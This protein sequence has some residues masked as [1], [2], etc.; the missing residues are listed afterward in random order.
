M[1]KMMKATIRN[2]RATASGKVY[3]AN[4]NTRAETRAQ[5]RHIDHERTEQNIN[6][7]FTNDGRVVRCG[8][9]DA[10]AFELQRYE[11]LYGEGQ[12]AKN[13][14]YIQDGH[15]ER[16]K[17]VTEVYSSRRTAPLETILQ[18]GSRD[19]DIDPQERREKLMKAAAKLITNMQQRWG[20]NIHLL[21]F[22][23]HMD[24]SGAD[25]I[26][27]R[28]TFSSL[29]RFGFRVPNQAQAF[30]A[31]GIQRPD[32]T[33]KEGKYNCP[34]MTFSELI[35][36]EF[37]DICERQGVVIDREV[38]NPSQKH[39]SVLEYKCQRMTAEVASLSAE[40]QQLEAVAAEQAQAI[41]AAQAEIEEVRAE[42]DTLRDQNS[43]SRTIQEALKQPD[44]PIQAEYLP[45]RKNLAGK[46][47]EAE[48]VKISRADYEWLRERATLTTAIRNAWEKLQQ[49]G[50]QLWAEV[51]RN[52]RVQ[53]AE[54]KAEQAERQ[55]RAD[56][57]TIRNLTRRAERAE[58]QAHEQE[59]F[60][61][62]QGIWQRFMQLLEERQQTHH[63]TR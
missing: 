34:L 30:E 27:V 48:A 26:H 12:R 63:R 29:D 37:Y 6:L 33:A 25:H 21:T 36:Q 3:N 5:E 52:A 59:Q 38:K 35:R 28:Y 11:H 56:A 55:T 15:P 62:R 47:V 4:H 18:L 40:K 13:D 24:E 58:A 51:D 54:A 61:K 42:R 57:V 43:V 7:Q 19:T 23:L 10:K 44:R 32:P 49:Y 8:S 22:S 46:V 60:M 2:G 39:L 45:A 31:M 9:F 17:T 1:E 53:T 50:R 16:C 41:E 14:R 20:E